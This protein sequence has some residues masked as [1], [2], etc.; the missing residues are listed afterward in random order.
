MFSTPQAGRID[1]SQ[2]SNR[3]VRVSSKM[4]LC[5]GSANREESHVT[6]IALVW[7]KAGGCNL[8]ATVDDFH[9][10]GFAR[11]LSTTASTMLHASVGVFV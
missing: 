10:H 8:T 6:R 2:D 5:T 11:Q 3:V 1:C 7:I 4:L 9:V